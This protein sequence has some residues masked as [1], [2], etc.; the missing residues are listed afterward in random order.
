[1]EKKK[2]AEMTSTTL[3]TIVLL[4]ISFIVIIFL[5]IQFDWTGRVDRE[6]CHQSVIYRAT[7]PSFGG[8]K[9]YVPLKCKTQKI[10]ITSGLIGGRCEEEFGESEGVLK[11]KVNDE[12]QIERAIAQE[13]VDCWSTMGE[14]K[15]SIFSQWLAESYGFDNV[16]PSCVICSRISF[17]EERLKDK[18]IDLGKVDVMDYMLR[19]KIADKDVTYYDYLMGEGGKISMENLFESVSKEEATDIIKNSEGEEVKQIL[20]IKDEDVTTEDVLSEEELRALNEKG[21]ELAVVFTQISSPGHADVFLNTL[22]AGAAFFGLSVAYKPGAFVGQLTRVPAGKA[23][24]I[25]A[26]TYSGGQFL[27][28]AFSLKKL[29]VSPLAK[30]LAAIA[31]ITVGIQQGNVA[32]NRAVTAG[33]CGD[34]SYGGDAKEGCSVVRTINYNRDEILQYCSVIESID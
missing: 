32:M 10:C 23:I 22:K 1:M 25:G 8:L 30:A 6:V 19:Y 16:Y 4:I 26:K 7:L 20:E 27:P 24:T 11:V 13:I 15:V 14:G 21:D 33:Y 3:V 12:R 9:E 17:D 31:V 2:R 28:K 5:Y 18:G 29:T 34:V